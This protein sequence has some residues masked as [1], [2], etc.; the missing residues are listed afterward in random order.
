MKNTVLILTNSTD[1]EHTESVVKHL[2]DRSESVFRFDVDSLAQ[3]DIGL[4]VQYKKGSFSFTLESENGTLESAD[5]KSVWYRRPNTFDFSIKDREQ[6]SFAE[7]ELKILLEGLWQSLEHVFW[8]S[9]PRNLENARK[10]VHQLRLA[11]QLGF[12][13]PETIVTNKPA[14]V[15]SFF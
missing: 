6:K 2:R 14:E 5:I 3:G 9:N 7:R 13:I 12:T 4:F 11:Q 10:K 15:K 1:G 8:M